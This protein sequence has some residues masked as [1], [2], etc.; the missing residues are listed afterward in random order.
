MSSGRRCSKR[1][2]DLVSKDSC[3]SVNDWRESSNKDSESGHNNNTSCSHMEHSVSSNSANSHD[4]AADDDDDDKSLPFQLKVI[5]T[6]I[7]C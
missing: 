2:S 7:Y 1:I 6:F 4:A 3:D 5:N